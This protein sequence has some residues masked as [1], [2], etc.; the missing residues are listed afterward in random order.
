M[1]HYTITIDNN[2][3]PFIHKLFRIQILCSWGSLVFVSKYASESI[4]EGANE[5]FRVKRSQQK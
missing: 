1:E 2:Q 4:L 3:I 5:N